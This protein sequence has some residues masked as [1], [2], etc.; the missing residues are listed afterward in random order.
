MQIHCHLD[1]VACASMSEA[2]AAS[3]L[4]KMK[5]TLLMLQ[6]YSYYPKDMTSSAANI[7]L[8]VE[9]A[10]RILKE[11]VEEQALLQSNAKKK[12]RYKYWLLA[13]LALMLV[14]AAFGVYFAYPFYYSGVVSGIGS[15]AILYFRSRKKLLNHSNESALKNLLVKK[16]LHYSKYTRTVLSCLK[17]CIG[18]S[19]H[20]LPKQKNCSSLS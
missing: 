20:H 5:D 13:S 3:Q 11:I 16:A 18:I 9:V 19:L 8:Y 1:Q 12:K 15:L 6:S 2:Q 4:Q 10:S 7:P 14:S 17:N